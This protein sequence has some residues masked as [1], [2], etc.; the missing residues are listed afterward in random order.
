M[1]GF[2]DI[3]LAAS[4]SYQLT[5]YRQP[6]QSLIAD[7]IHCLTQAFEPDGQRLYNGELITRQSHI[8]Q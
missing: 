3:E 8:K 4:P 7:G 6:M 5:T 1:V 2:D